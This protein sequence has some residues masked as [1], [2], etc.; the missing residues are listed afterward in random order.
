MLANEPI[1]M[2]LVLNDHLKRQINIRLT[3]ER[4]R[5]K[6]EDEVNKVYEEL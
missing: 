4:D 2:T 6:A 3:A 1:L 5:Q